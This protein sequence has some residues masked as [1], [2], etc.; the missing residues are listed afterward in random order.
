MRTLWLPIS[1]LVTACSTPA[2]ADDDPLDETDTD[3]D[4]A[5]ETDRTDD[6]DD[7]DETEET[8][9]TDETDPEGCT[10]TSE[11]TG[12]PELLTVVTRGCWVITVNLH[13]VTIRTPSQANKVEYWGD[14]HENLNGKHIKDWVTTRR[15]LILGDGTLL[16][17]HGEGPQGVMNQLTVYDGPHVRTIENATETIT[18]SSDELADATAR[19]AA[20]ADGETAQVVELEDQVTQY[21]NVY[22]QEEDE[23]GTPL[24]KVHETVQ[25]GETGGLANPNNVR[26]YYDD[27]RLGHT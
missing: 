3:T 8:E 24:E 20:E 1:L 26:D 12:D 22:S 5:E 7:T 13:T 18:Y 23:G 25:L 21:N 4:A 9:E 14:P 27:E 19:E 16:T 15:S 11:V 17:M 10:F 2:P 6:S